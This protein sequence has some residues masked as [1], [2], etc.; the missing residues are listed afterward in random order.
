MQSHPLAT[1]PITPKP[2]TMNY[3]ALITII[4]CYLAFILWVT[5]EAHIAPTEQDDD[6]DITIDDLIN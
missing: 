4:I 2:T 6:N 3:P 5:Y 1:S